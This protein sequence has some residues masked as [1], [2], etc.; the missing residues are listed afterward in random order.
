MESSEKKQIV[1]ELTEREMELIRKA[2]DKGAQ[3][4]EEYGSYVDA[5]FLYSLSGII[6]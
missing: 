4:H 1:L 5:D 6:R 2:L 3:E